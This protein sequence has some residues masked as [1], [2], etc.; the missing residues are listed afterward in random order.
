MIIP[1]VVV[2]PNV[3]GDVIHEVK[4][5]QTLWQIAISYE[6]KIDELKRLNNLVDNNIYPGNRL[7]IKKGVVWTPTS[8]VETPTVEATSPPTSLTASTMTTIPP[9][10]TLTPLSGTLSTSR[11]N[12]MAIAMGII[13]LAL[14]GGGVFAW[15]GNSKN[16][17]K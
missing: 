8:S 17:N 2:T 15:L 14:L 1:V 11:N 5:G 12:I 3:D 4:A 9:T 13:A 7:L 6:T 10:L 16:N